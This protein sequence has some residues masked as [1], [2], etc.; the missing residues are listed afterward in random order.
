MVRGRLP[1]VRCAA[2]EP[3]G[4]FLS[5][6][7][8]RM[9]FGF[10]LAGAGLIA[11]LAA[12]PAA[13][14]AQTV[15][16]AQSPEVAAARRIVS[17]V[18]L[19]AQEYRLAWSGG[20]IT[21]P[22][23]WDEARLFV[24]EARKSADALPPAV[25]AD[26]A[27][28]LELLGR[29]LADRM[30]AESLASA[31]ADLERRL[32]VALG[33]PLD[34]R[35]AREPSLASGARIFRQQCAT[36]HGDAGHGDGP[37]AAGLT[38][39]PADLTDSALVSRTPLDY[40]RR[41]T[42]GTPGTAMPAFSHLTR[43]QRWDV[44]A[45]VFA[46][47]DT[48]ARHGR[49]GQVAVVFGTVRGLL[50]GAMALAAH[51]EPEAAA[52]GV[53]DAY[54]AYE[55]VETSLA[56][57]DPGVVKLAEARFTA[58]REAAGAGLPAAE[59]Q[60]R[61]AELFASL[62]AS[63]A[64]L[65]RTHSGTGLFAESFLLI[66]REG[67]EAILVIG[68]IMA[69]LVKAGATE[70][71]AHVRWGIAL[72]VAASLVTAALLELLFRV[73]PAQR[74]A[75]EGG[76]ML[77]AAVMLFFVSYWLVSKVEVAAWTR[78]VKGHI[79]QAAESGSG[80]ALA[81]TAF[82]AVYREG[83][84]TVLFYKALYVT[85]AA[86]GAA[87]ITAGLVAGLAALVAVYVGIERFGLRLPMRPFFAVTGGTLA[88]MAFVFAGDGVKELQEGGYV[89]SSLITGGPRAEFFGVYPTW[90]SLGLQALILAAIAGA[91]LYAFVLRPRSPAPPAVVPPPAEHPS[92]SGR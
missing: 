85:G 8:L 77:V 89:P 36:C 64:A 67:F 91:L 75:L 1:P 56:A 17:T 24:G 57:S 12:A 81:G 18:Q 38:P 3:A 59:L 44:V 11:A 43:E 9:V 54:L 22:G 49:S 78:F 46:L 66:V 15:A 92:S 37:G 48:T 4:N 32:T 62:A 70:R 58:L 55:A 10:S 40:F 39:R 72:A 51:G 47:T 69:V 74:E 53:L 52:R 68:A 13:V 30:P 82:V 34:E 71:Q 2:P 6:M 86:G 28:R 21:A 42:E 19:A 45:H 20:T 65:S 73:T 80:L 61:R 35:P 23:E 26:I 29:Q 90:E 63:E 87:P 14:E 88:F 33:V 79:R 50:G 5:D 25:R 84:E 83:F 76:V 31:A 16:M 41:V 7:H 60:R 27:R